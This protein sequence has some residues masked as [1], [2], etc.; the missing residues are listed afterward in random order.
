MQR[1]AANRKVTTL[2]TRLQAPRTIR[3]SCHPVLA[4]ARPVVRVEACSRSCLARTGQAT[5]RRN[6]NMVSSTVDHPSRLT[7]VKVLGTDRATV[8]DTAVDT[9]VDIHLKGIMA[10]P[11][12]KVWVLVAQRRW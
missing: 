2:I 10:S 9:A 5:R 6:S 11:N 3:T 7:M 8:V 4:P 1:P 12:D